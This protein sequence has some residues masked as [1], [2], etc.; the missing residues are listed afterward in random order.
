MARVLSILM[1]WLCAAPFG[2]FGLV[3]WADAQDV[4]P[5]GNQCSDAMSTVWLGLVVVVVAI[6]L[7]IAII[8]LSRRRAGHI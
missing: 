2:F 8:W 1:I 7:S 6:C 4:C 5:N 3:A